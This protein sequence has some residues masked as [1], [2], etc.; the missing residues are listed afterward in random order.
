MHRLRYALET[1]CGFQ[2]I[3]LKDATLN[4]FHSLQKLLL[5]E[6]SGADGAVVLVFYAGH[7]LDISGQVHWIPVD[8]QRDEFPTYQNA[9]K[10]LSPIHDMVA[11]R[12]ALLLCIQ[13]ACRSFSQ[14]ASGKD[15]MQLLRCLSES[16]NDGQVCLV[17]ACDEGKAPEQ[18]K[19]FHQAAFYGCSLPV[20]VSSRKSALLATETREDFLEKYRGGKTYVYPNLS[21]GDFLV[22]L[23]LQ[24]KTPRSTIF[25][26][27]V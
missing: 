12:R 10:F 5:Q 3:C 26:A 22:G 14:S 9:Y 15:K 21:T 17:F 20:P 8:A 19:T 11:R 13:D 18:H 2:V 7:A 1:L 4:D 16:R 25:S 27:T 6:V 24:S 23:V